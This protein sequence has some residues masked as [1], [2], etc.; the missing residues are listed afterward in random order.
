MKIID[1][2]LPE[3][4]F[5]RLRDLVMYQIPWFFNEKINSGH[6]LEDNTSYFTHQLY[7]YEIWPHIYSEYFHNFKVLSDKLEI[8]SLTRMKLNLY[9]RTEKNEMH[10]PHTDYRI[11]HKGCI[12]SFN[13]CNGGTILF[14]NNGKE[15]KVDSVENRALLF[16]PSKPHSSLS[17][18]DAKARWNVN[19]NYF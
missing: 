12:L 15:T 1:N 19:I 16:D 10:T 7:N 3:E 5:K 11:K 6:T 18:T 8:V 13:T 9:T 17:C 14:D 4:D 2:F